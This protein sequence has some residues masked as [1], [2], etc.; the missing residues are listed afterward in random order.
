[1]CHVQ[2]DS[3]AGTSEFINEKYLL[4]FHFGVDDTEN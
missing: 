4:T 1:M 2:T 3:T